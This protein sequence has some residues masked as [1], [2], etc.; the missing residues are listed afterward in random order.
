MLSLL[1]TPLNLSKMQTC[2]MYSLHGTTPVVGSEV[3][4]A[5]PF[6]WSLQDAVHVFGKKLNAPRFPVA[7]SVLHSSRCLTSNTMV[8]S[9]HDWWPVDIL[10]F[11]ESIFR[12]HTVQSSM[13]LLSV[14]SYSSSLYY[15][16]TR[17]SVMWKWLFFMV[18]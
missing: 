6:C 10:R 17:R 9:V 7:V 13:M 5:Q 11:L 15:S 8:S 3:A 1:M 2:L 18:T 4:V 14:L 12:M 16:L